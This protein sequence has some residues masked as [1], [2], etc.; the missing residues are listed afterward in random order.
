MSL[1]S[2]R[3]KG[4]TLTAAALLA[5]AGCAT[6]HPMPLDAFG[7]GDASARRVAAVDSSAL[8]VAASSL[9]HARI[10]PIRIN[11][12]DGLSAD[13]AAVV[14]VIANPDLRA[15]RAGR[16]VAR[17]NLVA[18]G[19]MPNPTLDG[20]L[21]VPTGANS[22]NEV[23]GSV[24]HAGLDLQAL[25]TRGADRDAARAQIESVDL[26][27]AWREWQV[28][29]Q[30]RLQVHR[31]GFLEQARDLARAGS[32][33][34]KQ[35][36]GALQ[37]AESLRVV[38]G[39]ELAAAESALE[40]VRR[41]ALDADL[42]VNRTRR[43]LNT[44]LGIA[45][46]SL[47]AIQVDTSSPLNFQIPSQGALQDSLE[48]RRLDLIALRKGYDSQ[49]A[50]LR[51]EILRQFPSI[52]IGFVRNKD[53]GNF[54]TI[55]PTVSIGLP[56][57]DRNQ[58][59]IAVARATREQLFREYEARVFTSR[60]QVDSLLAERASAFKRIDNARAAAA[61]QERLE[62]VLREARTAGVSDIV[63]LYQARVELLNRRLDV[64]Q[65]EMSLAELNTALE[66]A[67]GI[68]FYSS[69]Q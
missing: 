8:R 15:A 6:Y 60:A 17:A 33:D 38:S 18:A 63:T 25:I 36:V 51:A 43:G 28:A 66:I 45:S 23:V 35:D 48:S 4:C 59:P 58:G 29:E 56:I 46:D 21:D 11:F 57:F 27:V 61:V 19:M 26:D 41:I 1:N 7:S 39:A 12:A 31:I 42:E 32:V 40:S 14:A 13:E 68:T 62:R 34:L 5:T 65:Q 30:A 52:N 69:R 50:S 37:A 53:T 2:R 9:R 10:A 64:I 55:G 67:S 22:A 24:L 54:F 3:T 20:E 47:L 16:K 49:D 44:T